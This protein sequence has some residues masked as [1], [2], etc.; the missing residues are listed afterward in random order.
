MDID[1][2]TMKSGYYLGNAITL[3]M[4]II[5]ILTDFKSITHR[6]I[7]AITGFSMIINFF[8]FAMYYA[9]IIT[10]YVLLCLWF[11]IPV[12]VITLVIVLKARKYGFLNFKHDKT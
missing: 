6:H 12:A 4:I 8:V 9:L 3:L 1:V 2:H 10:D 5:N 7:V 11:N